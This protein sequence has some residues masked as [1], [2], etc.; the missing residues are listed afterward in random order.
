M[1]DSKQSDP[2]ANVYPL[3]LLFDGQCPLCKL[4][5]DWLQDRD[6]DR[7]LRFVDISAPGFDPALYTNDHPLSMGDLM[8][9]IHAVQADGR[10]VQGVEV[11][12]LA[13]GAVGLGAIAGPTAWPVLR[14][15]FDWTYRHFARN[16]YRVSG[17]LQP[18]ISRLAAAHA[19]KRAQSC[20]S[21][22]VCVNSD[23]RRSV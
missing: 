4:E 9:L 19:L 21:G 13:Y 15:L 20:A 10:L 18:L 23:G 1:T 8:A 6:Q 11:F 16:R 5:M 7:R 12:R 2:P 14:P 17:W 22:H 3:T